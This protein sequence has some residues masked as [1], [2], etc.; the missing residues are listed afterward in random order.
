TAKPSVI[1]SA[2]AASAPPAGAQASAPIA[3][4][5]APPAAQKDTGAKNTSAR[6][7]STK[8]ASAKDASPG[9]PRQTPAAAT[10]S[11]PRTFSVQIA[12][13]RDAKQAGR[14]AER[15]KKSGY[16]ADVRHMESA[17]T[18]WAVRVGT[19]PTRDQAESARAALAR[20]GFPGFIL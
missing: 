4:P 7:A 6:D 15:V 3:L 14:L 10:A 17:N 1:A 12:A 2:P 11:K 20:K 19:Y 9:A 16:P 5:P 18:P 13:F 8:N